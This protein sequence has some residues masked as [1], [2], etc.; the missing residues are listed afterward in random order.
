VFDTD[1]TA[2]GRSVMN[3]L[4]Y[5]LCYPPYYGGTKIGDDENGNCRLYYE[6]WRTTAHYEIEENDLKIFY[7][8]NK[9]YMLF[10]LL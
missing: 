7:N 5:F 3:E 9:N 10:K 8:D 4:E 6:A 1:S 2:H